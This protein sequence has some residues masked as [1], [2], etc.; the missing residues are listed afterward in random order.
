MKKTVKSL[1]IA[2]SVAAIAGIGAISFAKW[3]GGT[4]ID[5][6]SGANTTGSISS[7]AWQSDNTLTFT[8][9]LMPVDQGEAG[10]GTLIL[11]AQIPTFVVTGN[12]TIT[13][14]AEDNNVANGKLYVKVDDTAVTA[15]DMTGLADN[16]DATVIAKLGETWKQAGASAT[17]T[18]SD[19]AANTPVTKYIGVVLVSSNLG[20]MSKTFKIK[21]A[22]A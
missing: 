20:D 17:W 1:I 13:V 18:G 3:E 21:V 22:I 15:P 2:A 4:S 16:Q 10:S 12:Y 14:T 9:N 11:A 7:I 19:L 6:T 5:T 8:G